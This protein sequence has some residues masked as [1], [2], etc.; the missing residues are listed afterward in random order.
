MVKILF[1]SPGADK[2]CE[3]TLKTFRELRYDVEHIKDITELSGRLSG[4]HF[5]AAVIR[6]ELPVEKIND[7]AAS[8]KQ[9]APGIPVILST[10]ASKF[11]RNRSA[12]FEVCR[13]ST[14]ELLFCV[15][16]LLERLISPSAFVSGCPEL[17]TEDIREEMRSKRHAELSIKRL[18]KYTAERL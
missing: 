18:S 3:G 11:F 13:N 2:S 9:R 5:D 7:I 14:A 16:N 4:S 17:L 6:A 1:I 10:N 12:A 15:E 8:L